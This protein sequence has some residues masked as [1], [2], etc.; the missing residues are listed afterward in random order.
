MFA[1]LFEKIFYI[2]KNSK[3]KLIDDVAEQSKSIFY[4][5]INKHLFAN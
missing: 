1:L 5:K 3:I 4:Y 2:Y